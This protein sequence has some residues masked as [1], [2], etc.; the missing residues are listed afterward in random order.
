MRGLYWTSRNLGTHPREQYS[1]G[2]ATVGLHN[3]SLDIPMSYTPSA[4]DVIGKFSTFRSQKSQFR[5][6]VRN[7]VR[8]L[9]LKTAAYH[10]SLPRAAL[11]HTTSATA[12]PSAATKS[13]S[14]SGGGGPHP[15]SVPV[16]GP[17]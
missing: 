14:R 11:V 9:A 4:I 13:R 15:R 1:N 10:M 17:R 7:T 16:D 3:V 12:N 2:L 5:R 6:S 8:R